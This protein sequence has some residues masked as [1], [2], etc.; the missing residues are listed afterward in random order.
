MAQIGRSQIGPFQI[1]L[2]ERRVAQAGFMQIGA[3][4]I[5][6]GEIDVREIL[7]GEVRWVGH[8]DP[9]LARGSEIHD[10]RAIRCMWSV[11]TRLR[12]FC[13]AHW[14]RRTSS[15]DGFAA[16]YPGPCRGLTVVIN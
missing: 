6:R 11:A 15:G 10:S 12:W 3:G 8:V 16:S 4:Q 5:G 7:L 14:A 2:L 9:L 1:R 13:A